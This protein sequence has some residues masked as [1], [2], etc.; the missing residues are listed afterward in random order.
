[1]DW[2][3]RAASAQGNQLKPSEAR[4]T[5]Q[6]DDSK[7]LGIKAVIETD[8][9]D[10]GTGSYTVFS[11]VAAE[12]L[13]LPI[14]RIEMK[15]GDSDLPPAAGSGGSF[16]AASS[17]SGIYL[18]CVKLREILATATGLHTDTICLDDGKIRQEVEHDP[19]KVEQA[20]DAMLSAM[21]K[22]AQLDSLLEVLPDVA[23]NAVVSTWDNVKNAKDAGLAQMGIGNGKLPTGKDYDFGD[24]KS[25]ALKDVVA[26]F[27]DQTITG[28]GQIMPGKNKKSYRQS[29]YGANFAEVAVHRVTGEIRVR[30][31]TGVFE[32]GRILNH[33]TAT[34][35]CY[36]GMIFGI[37]SALMEQLIVD[38]HDGR[39]CN[40]WRNTCACECGRATVRRYFAGRRRPLH[41]SYAH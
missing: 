24:D 12:L 31:M 21:E 6:L 8:M 11:Q 34:S 37:G 7:R 22:L 18:A 4:A 26:S 28:V 19:S 1:M 27:D 3:R 10:I 16:G 30:R 17:G 20:T 25:H 9:T 35:Q 40:L 14:D 29:S 38:K 2:Y 33:K 13:G 32:A 5:L 39:L 41:Q 36:G 15:L 23:S